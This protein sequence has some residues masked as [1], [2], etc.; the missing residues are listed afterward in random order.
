MPEILVRSRYRKSV[1]DATTKRKSIKI[2]PIQRKSTSLSNT[3]KNNV[4]RTFCNPQPDLPSVGLKNVKR[5]SFGEDLIKHLSQNTVTWKKKLLKMGKYYLFPNIFAIMITVL[6]RVIIEFKPNDCE[7]LPICISSDKSTRAIITIT[8]ILNLWMLWIL[9]VIL[10][11]YVKITRIVYFLIICLYIA[12]YYMLSNEK[13]FSW[14]PIYS[15]LLFLRFIRYIFV[16]K[17]TLLKDMISV[18]YSSQGCTLILML[19]YIFFYFIQ[20]KLKESLEGFWFEIFNLFYFLIFFIFVRHSLMK[21]AMYIF[22]Q[23]FQTKQ[24][25]FLLLITARI[26]LSYLISFMSCPFLNFQTNKITQYLIIYTYSNNLI[27]LYTRFNLFQYVCIKIYRFFTKK[28]I[29]TIKTKMQS[30]KEKK[31]YIN[32]IISGCTL[33]IVFISS[34]RMIIYN[35][36]PGNIIYSNCVYLTSTRE[37][38][39]LFVAVNLFVT[40]GIFVYMVYKKTALFFYKGKLD[41]HVN[42]YLL[43]MTNTLFE[44]TISFF[45]GKIQR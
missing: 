17:K 7:F 43:Y 6:V 1:I 4:R 42:I 41:Y 11:I 20:E 15:F 33:D 14:F 21:Y 45:A 27:G 12:L 34:C 18:I 22:D 36:W 5:Y 35:L 8:D 19:N 26:S 3:R 37:G 25:T 40:L 23:K 32:K 38:M 39:L 9:N 29:K 30:N 28:S 10:E 44:T 16:L 13:N 2:G 31:Q 24:Q